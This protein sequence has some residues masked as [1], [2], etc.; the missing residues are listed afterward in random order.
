MPREST[1]L[2]GPVYA[3]SS[4]FS[5]QSINPGKQLEVFPRS[6]IQI[7]GKEL[8]DIADALFDLP[9]CRA[10]VHASDVTQAG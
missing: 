7:E 2:D 9:L 10:H 3:L 6:Q 1:H 8:R 4:G 5:I